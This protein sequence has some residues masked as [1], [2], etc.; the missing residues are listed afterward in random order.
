MRNQIGRLLLLCSP[1]GFA[2][3]GVLDKHSSRSDEPEVVCGSQVAASYT[4]P[5][6]GVLPATPAACCLPVCVDHSQ[7]S[8][9]ESVPQPAPDRTEPKPQEPWDGHAGGPNG[10]NPGPLESP[11][12][13]PNPNRASGDLIPENPINR[14]GNDVLT[15]PSPSDDSEPWTSVPQD[16]PRTDASFDPSGQGNELPAPPDIPAIQLPTVDVPQATSWEEADLPTVPQMSDGD[17][18]QFVQ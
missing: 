2:G 12:E 13:T 16:P 18:F 6:W 1:F 3:C 9:V 7:F 14:D 17:L 4:V 11:A 10:L 5:Q 15:T 8:M